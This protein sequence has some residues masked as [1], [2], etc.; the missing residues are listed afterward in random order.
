VIIISPPLAGGGLP[1]AV[2]GTLGV[3]TATTM[4]L[5]TAQRVAAREQP[6]RGPATESVTADPGNEAAER[7]ATS[8]PAANPYRLVG[9]GV[10]DDT[11]ALEQAIHAARGH[12]RLPAGRYRITRTIAVD[13][14]RT[15]YLA[16]SGAGLACL[17]MAGPGPALRVIGTHFRSADPQGVADQVWEE[18]R[19]PLVDG[20]AIVGRHA[21]AD[22]IQAVGT[23]QLTLTRLHI[24]A[25]RHA[26][27]LTGSNRNVIVSD[28]HV[29][30]NRGVGIY[31]DDVNLHQ[32]NITGCH[33]SY[34]AGGGIVSRGGN[35]RNIHVSGCDLESNMSPD[36]LP[37]A[38]ILIDC[39]GSTHGTAEVAITGCTIQHNNPSPDSANI[40]VLGNSQPRG[41]L[42]VREGNV[43]I[44]GNVLSDVQVNLHLRHCR[45]VAVAG[46]TLW[47]G[48]RHNVLIEDCSHIVMGAN[49]LDRN[50]RYDYGNTQQANNGVLFRRCQDCTVGG[51]HVTNVWREPAGVI[52]EDCRRMNLT[53]CTILDCDRAGLLL[54]NV[55]R[56]LVANCLIRDDRPGSQS[57][58]LRVM[59]GEG[60]LIVGNLLDDAPQIDP[61]VA[62]AHHNLTVR[63][64]PGG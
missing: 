36:A 62:E 25:T 45:G 58:S 4:W 52:L 44:T 60:N 17:E 14:A 2:L 61:G 32:S 40:R 56:S 23:M 59:G 49:N 42:P 43:T 26:I 33:I 9:D 27:R 10:A 5:S 8:A 53:G 29:Y 20:L 37:T 35:V 54:R 22:G 18:E 64:R 34:N 55:T 19:M 41:A 31:Y 51:L 1:H 21:E 15:G 48:Y 63:S 39:Q 38:N 57:A 6:G 46:N 13:L 47:Q 11:D 16:I 50:P 24:R 30:H 7:P 28:C 12:I 3:L